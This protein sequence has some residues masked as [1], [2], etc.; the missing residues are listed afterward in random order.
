MTNSHPIWNTYKNL[1]FMEAF[2]VILII[3][4]VITFD[5]G[6]IIASVPSLEI[7]LFSH[8]SEVFTTLGITL[9]F[10]GF[11]FFWEFGKGFNHEQE[12]KQIHESLRRI[13]EHLG[14]TPDISYPYTEYYGLFTRTI[15]YD[16]RFK[17]GIRPIVFTDKTMYFTIAAILLVM[18]ILFY[19]V[20]YYQ[21]SAL[22]LVLTV[23]WGVLHYYFCKKS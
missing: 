9:I 10:F 6:W 18:T 13:E 21:F 22:I 8:A 1:I 12:I 4:G 20:K 15:E 23:V 11:T 16:D 14:C 2:A 17:N 5:I 7:P 19:F 3:C